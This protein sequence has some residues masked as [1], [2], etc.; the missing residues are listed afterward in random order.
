[1]RRLFVIAGALLVFGAAIAVADSAANAVAIDTVWTLMAAVL[2]FL[3]QAGFAMLETGFT[4]AKNAANIMMKNLMDFSLG[5]LAF[6]AVGFGIMFGADAA[7]LIGTDKFFLGG[8][9]VDVSE[10]ISDFTF[11]MFQVVFAATAATIVSGAVAERTQFKAYLVYSVFITALIYPVVGH[12][13]WGG[14]WLSNLGM[15][16]FAGSTVV[17]SVGGWAG[18]AGAI[19][20][21]AREGKYIRANGNGKGAGANGGK[22]R[23]MVN[24]IQ[25]HNL[26]LA[27]LGVFLLWFGWFGFNAGSTVAGTD[28]SIAAIAVTTNLAAAAGVL[29]ALVLAWIISGKPD[30]TFALNGAI[31]GLVAITAGCANVSPGSAVVIGFLGGVLVVLAVQFI[32]RVLMV[33][34]PVGAISAHGVVGAWG[35][36][37]VGLFAQEQF[38]GTNGLFFG[39]GFGQLGIQILG[40]LAVFAWTFVASLV[41]FSVIKA[42]V[43]LRVSR[44]QELRGLDIEE[45][46]AEAY[47]DFEVY[48]TR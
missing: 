43:G 33:D 38:G 39:G 22:D 15:I 37:A 25:G 40:V 20:L 7:G 46:G 5:S 48:T 36:I 19:V 10:G 44:D 14:G 34:D 42:T 24:A 21:G 1:M 26:P 23:V 27:A 31:A 11:W 18:L 16:D 32:D 12:W 29:G 8:A 35:T 47:T 2:V 45:H 6:W 41:L 9:M 4:R 17:H 3:M 13:I 30:P 28:L